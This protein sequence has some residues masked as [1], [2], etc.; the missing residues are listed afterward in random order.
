[1]MLSLFL[2]SIESTVVATAM[3]TIIA[4]LGGLSIYAWVF[5]AYM[6]AS[7]TTVPVYGK[8]SDIYGRRRVY[9]IAMA[10]FLTGAT[11]CA[12]AQ[13]MTQLVLFRAI[14]GLGA[15]GLQPLAFIIIGDIFTFE[16]RARVQGWFSSVW[17][18]SS[19]VG[20]LVGGFLVDQVSWHWVFLLNLPPGILA[21]G[22]MILA[23]H[24]VS[25]RAHGSV[26]Y[27]GAILLSSG[28][29]SLLLALFQL[30]SAEEWNALAFW[31]L[32]AISVTL[33]VS[34][35]WVERR[36]TNPILPLPL[37]RERLF[38]VAMGHG[39]LAAFAL[40][41]SASF[42]PLFVESVLGT[43]ATVAGATLTPQLLGWVSA[44]VIGTRLLLRV[45]YRSLALTGMTS[46]V[47]GA[48]LMTQ[49]GTSTP[50][51][52]LFINVTLAGIGM[53]LS[54]PC[55]LI[56]VQSWVPRQ[57][58]GT[59]TA[60]VQFSRSIGGAIGVSVMGVV[61]AFQLAAGLTAAGI[62]PETVSL[63]ALIDANVGAVAPATLLVVRGALAGAV[64]SVF[65]VALLAAIGA[66]IATALAPRG[67]IGVRETKDLPGF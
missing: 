9:L 8:L 42:I 46:L 21:A 10:I 28:I 22:L 23:W 3:P 29:V 30:N 53:G 26:D 38:A 65:V 63:S 36:A 1:M 37:F 16:Q 64:R 7:T 67:R 6:L 27:V 41:G 57:S 33:L 32:L 59:A 19:I 44:S 24:D 31:S 54:I 62:N 25:P 39:F 18:I 50:Q 15:G 43:S 45:S 4:Q 13:T 48:L 55:F 40:I 35:L 47:T 60:T 14:Q 66:W 12:Q 20:P 2:A 49:I 34:L 11:L 58:L 56:A 51:W 5:S 61:L 17:G 52:V